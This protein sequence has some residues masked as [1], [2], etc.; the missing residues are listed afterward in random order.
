[1]TVDVGQDRHTNGL[2][3]GRIVGRIGI[4]VLGVWIWG[5]GYGRS[6]IGQ[7]MGRG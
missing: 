6:A 5:G 1:M 3:R 4:V 2:E 7:R